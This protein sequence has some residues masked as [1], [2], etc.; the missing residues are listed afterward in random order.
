MSHQN[1][2]IMVTDLVRSRYISELASS[3]YP[4]LPGSSPFGKTY[5]FED[6]A[7]EY[8]L[9]WIAGSKLP[10]LQQLL[11]Q[12]ENKLVLPT[13]VESII[14]HGLKYREKKNDNI[15][16][17]EVET[18][19]SIMIKLGYK[20]PELNDEIFLS[21]FSSD[22]LSK[23]PVDRIKLRDL[24]N[25][26]QQL[27]RNPDNQSR[28]YEFQ[29]FLVELFKLWSLDPRKAFRITG[30]E[31][32]GSIE[33]DNEI[34]L[35]EARWRRKTAERDDLIV[36]S[37]K[38]GNKSEWTRGFFISVNGFDENALQYLTSMG[39]MNFIAMKGS[40]LEIILSGKADLIELLRRKVRLLAE[41]KKFYFFV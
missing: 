4:W 21:S 19:N 33:L 36:F 27:K 2:L 37:S 28:G 31:T 17:N 1:F 12:A 18:I 11:E 23:V 26:Y 15:N 9:T 25:I 6:I 14:D 40:E 30:E 13:V 38:I 34:Y 39:Q 16:R 32:D 20:I 41:E 10:A 24:G 22:V 3:L 29:S 35:L 8:G 5:T 7:N